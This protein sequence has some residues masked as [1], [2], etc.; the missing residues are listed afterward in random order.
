MIMSFARSGSIPELQRYAIYVGLPLVAIFGVLAFGNPLFDGNDDTGLAMLGAGFGLAVEPEPHLIFSHFGYGVLLNVVSRLAG[1]CAHG[2][3]TLAALGLGMGL[4]ARAL[5]EQSRANGYLVGTALLVAIGCVFTRAFLLQ[6]FTTTAAVLFGAAIGCWLAVLRSGARSPGLRALIYTAI[7]LSFL[8]R[9]SAAMLGLVVVIPTLI[10]LVWLGPVDSRKPTFRLMAVIAVI[11]VAIYVTDKSA[12]VLSPDWRDAL[13]YNQIRALFNDYFRIP[14]IPGA[15]EYAKVGWSENDHA[16]FMNWYFLHPIF[17]YDNIKYLAG[18]LLTQAPLF[19]FSG[20]SDWLVSLRGSPLLIAI[21]VSQ[22]L[23]FALLPSCRIIIALL[24]IGTLFALAVS[25]LTGRPPLFRV[26]FSALSV[27]FLCM[28][29]FLLA[30]QAGARSLRYLA[31]ALLL[32]I[33]LYAGWT[34]IRAHRDM[35]AQ[36]AA[37][38]SKLLE[39]RPYFNGTVISWGSALVWDWLITPTKVYAPVDGAIIPSIG[40]ATRMPVTRSTLERLGIKDLGTTLCTKPDIRVIASLENIKRLQ[41]FC[42]EH[43]E[44]RPTY[45]LVFSHPMTEIYVSGTRE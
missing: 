6:Q 39:V 36:A 41:K 28:L 9:P 29:P 2:W 20:V 14:W 26:Q 31:S 1:P 23:L 45:D 15:P 34:A 10:W 35:S 32:G 17:D 19:V 33:A 12:Y 16:M 4:Y 43:Y 42:E 24:M 11:A 8:I 18:T 3:A 7:V 40:L 30:D 27:A 37:Y 13:E 5:C 44:G 21:C 38:R 22:L 25:G